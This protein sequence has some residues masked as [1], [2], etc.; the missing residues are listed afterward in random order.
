MTLTVDLFRPHVSTP[1]IV[2]LPNQQRTELVLEEVAEDAATH[3]GDRG[4]SLFFKGNASLLLPQATY[5]LHHA[6]LAELAI[7]LVPVAKTEQ[8]YRYQAYFNVAV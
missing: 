3:T 5:E 7:F 8:G 6:Q 4:F 2:Q 1:F